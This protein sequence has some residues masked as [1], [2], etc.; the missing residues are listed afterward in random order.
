M[1]KGLQSVFQPL[2]NSACIA[3]SNDYDVAHA[4]RV[5][6]AVS[7]IWASGQLSSRVG[8]PK[9]SGAQTLELNCPISAKEVQ[10]ALRGLKRDKAAGCD[11]IPNELLRYGGTALCEVLA[12][13]FRV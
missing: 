11:D 2:Q 4:A 9:L 5:S 3:C 6:A 1:V 7:E 13:V 10:R 8:S 12:F